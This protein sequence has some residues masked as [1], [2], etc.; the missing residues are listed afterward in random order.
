[1]K[2]KPRSY[3]YGARIRKPEGSGSALCPKIKIPRRAF[4]TVSTGILPCQCSRMLS[5]SSHCGSRSWPGIPSPTRL[6]SCQ[7]AKDCGWSEACT[8]RLLGTQRASAISDGLQI[9]NLMTLQLDLP[10][11]AGGVPSVGP[12][13]CQVTGG[14]QLDS[15]VVA[16]VE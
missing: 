2:D 16:V 15:Q 7:R 4:K 6:L 5:P 8:A 3:R 11:R 13:A 9:T 12:A 1:M 14:Q 10:T